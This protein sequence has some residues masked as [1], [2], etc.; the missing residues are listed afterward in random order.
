[1][2]VFWEII[3]PWWRSSLVHHLFCFIMGDFSGGRSVFNCR[4]KEKCLSYQVCWD[5]LCSKLSP[6]KHC[7]KVFLLLEQCLWWQQ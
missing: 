7:G 1:M 6:V 4:C 5:D 2:H 3:S